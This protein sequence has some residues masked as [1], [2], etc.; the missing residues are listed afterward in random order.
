MKTQRVIRGIDF[1]L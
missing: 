1:F